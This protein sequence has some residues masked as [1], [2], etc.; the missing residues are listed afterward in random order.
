MGRKSGLSGR[1]GREPVQS[2]TLVLQPW[3]AWKTT[4]EALK[5]NPEKK[6]KRSILLKVRKNKHSKKN[7]PASDAGRFGGVLGNKRVY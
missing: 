3:G 5:Q 1:G 2:L 7:L 6:K 4:P